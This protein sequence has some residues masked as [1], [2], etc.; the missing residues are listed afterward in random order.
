MTRTGTLPVLLTSPA[1]ASACPAELE[2]GICSLTDSVHDTANTHFLALL[3]PSKT[4]SK[5]K[6]M[7]EKREA[8]FP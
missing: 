8:L 4:V 5:E 2:T 3:L 1:M 6:Q 7:E